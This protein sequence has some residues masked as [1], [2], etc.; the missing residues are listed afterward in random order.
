LWKLIA[1]GSHA[2]VGGEDRW[3][4][5]PTFDRDFQMCIRLANQFALN[6]PICIWLGY[7]FPLET[8]VI[9][10]SSTV[11]RSFTLIS[12]FPAQQEMGGAFAFI[13]NSLFAKHLLLRLESAAKESVHLHVDEWMMRQLPER[14]LTMHHPI[15]FTD[16]FNHEETANAALKLSPFNKICSFNPESL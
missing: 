16:Y 6:E 15:V 8:R 4:I 13:M 3:I 7:H 1:A 14:Q 11:P 2:M 12:L 9:A 10:S 5:G